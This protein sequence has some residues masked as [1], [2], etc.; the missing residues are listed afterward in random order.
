MRRLSGLPRLALALL[1]V[2][3]VLLW[4]AKAGADGTTDAWTDGND[5]GAGAG[6]SDSTGGSGSTGG[7]G[8]APV[9]EWVKLAPEEALIAD[10]LVESGD[11][12]AR[13]DGPGAWYRHTCVGST[14]STSTIVWVADR[15]DP[16]VLARQAADRA[17]IPS[18]PLAFNPAPEEGAVVNV[19]T[20]LWVDRSA[21]RPVSAQAAAGGITV[22]ATAAP[23]RVVWEMGNGDRV[24]C[25]GPGTAYDRSKRPAEQTTD[26]SYTY[27]ASSARAE[28]GTF[29]VTATVSWAVTWSVTGAAGGG[30]LGTVSR[31]QSVRM[32]VRE[33][34]A[35]NR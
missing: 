32:P 17:A 27:R 23:Q 21:W 11:G 30:S 13:G 16:L 5:V 15:V 18:P 4:P 24:T 7:G 35:V 14:G 28:G 26:C 9:C 1:A 19:E 29:R 6:S 20:W 8:A 12:P 22:T 31:S 33:I 10:R 25:D 3:S 2:L 34:Q